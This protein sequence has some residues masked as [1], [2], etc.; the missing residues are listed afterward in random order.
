MRL[1]SCLL[2][3]LVGT[4]CDE[5]LSTTQAVSILTRTPDFAS[6]EGMDPNLVTALPLSQLDQSATIAFTG[7][8]Q[9]PDSTSQEPPTP[10]SGAIVTLAWGSS[11]ITL[12]DQS[13]NEAEGT[14]GA[15]SIPTETCGDAALVYEDDA[16]YTTAISL[17]GDNFS[18]TVVA[19][20]AIDANNVAFTPD[21]QNA[22]GAPPGFNL[23]EH[24]DPSAGLHVSWAADLV[25]RD[26]PAFLTLLRVNYN[27]GTW[28]AD[29]NNPVFDNTPRQPAEMID[30]VLGDPPDFADIPPTAFDA[31][32]M[33]FLVLT[34]TE[35]ST[36]T[37][38]LQ[39]GSG[40]L[41]GRGVAWA[42]WVD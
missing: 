25:A 23:Q 4:G 42:F 27:N 8:G 29:P 38:G 15:T 41:A 12:C 3:L 35:L 34:S 40:A 1:S 32:G 6:A 26:R 39:L 33:Y 18:I 13:A 9:R 5:L 36:A 14:Y 17:G 7:I 16:E 21:F 20:P 10:V 31:T 24:S 30:L 11:T 37:E 22:S 28:E 2:V 19:P